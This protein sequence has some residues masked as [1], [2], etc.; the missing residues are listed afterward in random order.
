MGLIVDKRVHNKESSQRYRS[1]STH[2]EAVKMITKMADEEDLEI[3]E[4]FTYIAIH[5]TDVETM[6]QIIGAAYKKVYGYSL[7]LQTEDGAIDLAETI[8][9]D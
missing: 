3:G 8:T 9:V 1:F 6:L 4:L 5:E 2:E 7:V